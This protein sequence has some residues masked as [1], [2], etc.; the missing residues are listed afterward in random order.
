VVHVRGGLLV[1]FGGMA[2]LDA[3]G[4]RTEGLRKWLAVLER[5]VVETVRS[6]L[7]VKGS[8]NVLPWELPLAV[9]VASASRQ[10]D[11]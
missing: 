5:I 8:G 11:T 9:V 1:N 2:H 4:L 6:G 7:G 10:K 3:L